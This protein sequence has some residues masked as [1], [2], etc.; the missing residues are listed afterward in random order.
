[1]D[2]FEN[3]RDALTRHLPRAAEGSGVKVDQNQIIVAEPGISIAD[4]SHLLADLTSEPEFLPDDLP[5]ANIR[6]KSLKLART[7]GR[8][9]ADFDFTLEWDNAGLSIADSFPLKMAQ[10][11]FSRHGERLLASAEVVLTL[12]NLELDLI[13]E[14]PSQV[15]RGRLHD[16]DNDKANKF[17]HQRQLA[18]SDSLKLRTLSVDASIPMRHVL[19]HLELEHLFHIGPVTM[20]EAMAQVVLAESAD[21]MQAGVMAQISIAV[22]NHEPVIVTAAGT[23]DT[24]GW[25]VAGSI[26]ADHLSFHISDLIE[27]LARDLNETAP[28]LPSVIAD[29]GLKQ[30][31]VSIDTHDS[32][33]AIDCTLSWQHSDAEL[34]VHAAKTSGGFDVSA[35][36]L[37]GGQI[38]KVAFAAGSDSVLMASY[39]SAGHQGL[40]LDQLIGVFTASGDAP[41][42]HGDTTLDIESVAL[43]LDEHSR[44]L[45]AAQVGAGIDLGKL[46]ELPLFG[47]LLP[48]NAKLG[49]QMTPLYMTDGFASLD[50]SRS[51]L[52]S[53]I[54]LP[55]TVNSGISIAASLQLGGDPISLDTGN[56]LSGADRTAPAD[57]ANQGKPDSQSQEPVNADAINWTE[58]D[59]KLGPVHL[60]RAGYA[61]STTDPKT[62]DLALDGS[63]SI[64]GLSLGLDG[65]GA[66]YD[67]PSRTLTP[68][69]QGMSID[70]KRG[71]LEIGGAFLNNDGDFAG[72]LVIGTEKFGL[73]A[74]AGFKMLEGTPSM[75]AYGVLDMPLGGPVFLFVEGLAAGFGIHRKIHMP[76]IEDVH[77]FPLIAGA[78]S[79]PADEDIDPGAEMRAL[80]EY[81]SPKLGEYFFA[82]GIKFNSFRLLHGFGVVV[83]SLGKSFELD[84]IGTANMSVPPELPPSVPALAR[85]ELDLMARF[86]PSE[87]FLSVEARLNPKSYVYGPLCHLS[88]GFA[89]YAWFKGERTGDFVLSIGGYHPQYER[90]AGYP[91]VP[92]I[93]LKY[94]VTPD[95]Y[96]KGDGYFALTPSVMMVGGG[97]HAQI[98]IDSLHAWADLS[99]DFVVGWEPFHYDA[100]VHIGIGAQWKCFHTSASADLHIWG[101]KFSGHANVDWSV[102][103]FDVEFGPGAETLP[104]PISLAKFKSSFL[105]IK[106]AHARASDEEKQL[107]QQSSNDILGLVV[108]SG[109]VGSSGGNNI[110]TGH[111]LVLT[112]STRIPATEAV[113]QLASDDMPVSG[114]TA[115]QLGIQPMGGVALGPSKLSIS[116]SLDDVVTDKIH[117]T[118]TPITTQVPAALWSTAYHV[119]KNAPPIPAITA[120]ELTPAEPPVPGKSAFKSAA[121]MRNQTPDRH[122][123]AEVH[124]ATEKLFDVVLLNHGGRKV[125]V[126]RAVQRLNGLRLS[127]AKN[128]VESADGVLAENLSEIGAQ[129]Y[130]QTFVEMGATVEI[131]SAGDSVDHTWAPPTSLPVADLSTLGIETDTLVA[132]PTVP[133]ER[134][135]LPEVT[136]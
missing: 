63:M 38:F 73:H 71:P 117:F 35:S 42:A 107:A 40:S 76:R 125:D 106:T 53:S 113:T 123:F 45:M 136:A 95:V 77:R 3:I 105:D 70:L 130:V 98:N 65:L 85:V 99:V 28:Q 7:P 93:E 5:I 103:S 60:I 2:S 114:I 1:M 41:V 100:M 30:L 22:T 46:G 90:P 58:V 10:M 59:M 80:H 74:L 126:I 13:L 6:L 127:E 16:L 102:F 20:T 4:V 82:A 86:A 21:E 9:D 101:P 96:I 33:F 18:R 37:L 54:T 36:L 27:S 133:L 128:R 112:L 23:V 56:A 120:L 121:S 19:L 64:A 131:R 104:F 111:E 68:R 49:V 134:S 110:V 62:L 78:S 129:Q 32:S 17:L 44:V 51:L 97:I 87:G 132:D 11:Q 47:T 79:P 25:S 69:L 88:G 115:S 124:V 135:T 24:Q 92:R 122:T 52:P 14:L 57:V 81:L 50:D 83:V 8:W 26:A 55:D 84:L 118:V 12:D 39:D 94:Q 29:I 43:A 89:F 72:K 15:V 66:H 75:F 109:V 61:M 108:A 31:A 67:F 91:I 116:V 48:D 119:D 34:I